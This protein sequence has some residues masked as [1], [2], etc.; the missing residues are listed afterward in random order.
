MKQAFHLDANW[1]VRLVVRK[2]LEARC[3]QHDVYPICRSEQGRLICT[4]LGTASGVSSL[5]EELR[6]IW[7]DKLQLRG[8]GQ[9]S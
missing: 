6:R 2:A 8:E 9:S 5:I 7:G 3:R 1:F 4:V